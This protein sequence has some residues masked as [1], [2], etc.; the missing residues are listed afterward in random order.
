[1][2]QRL[3]FSFLFASL[4]LTSS[5]SNESSNSSEPKILEEINLVCEG[6]STRKLDYEWQSTEPEKKVYRFVRTEEESYLY[7]FGAGPNPK[8]F[9]VNIDEEKIS[10]TWQT[11]KDEEGHSHYNSI[12]INRFTGDV[13]DWYVIDAYSNS[14]TIFEG[15]C[16]PQDQKF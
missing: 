7:G 8:Y 2:K 11:Q 13:K 16:K 10:L 14:E 5:C 9:A 1:M 15:S 4:L 3:A 12:D 6:E